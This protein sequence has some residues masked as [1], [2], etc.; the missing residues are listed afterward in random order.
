MLFE[1]EGILAV[2]F[3][4][5]QMLSIFLVLFCIEAVIAAKSEKSTPGLLF[6]GAVFLLAIFVGWFFHEFM[7]F[8]YMLIPVALCACGFGIARYVR[9]RNL[10]K[11]AVYNEDGV[12]EDDSML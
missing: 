4:Y 3:S 9:K 1:S 10:E 11:G 6:L 2:I 8:V 7:F 12:L 5:G